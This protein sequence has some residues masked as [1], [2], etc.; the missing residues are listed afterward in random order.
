MIAA[1]GLEIPSDWQEAINALPEPFLDRFSKTRLPG[2]SPVAW[3][4]V[5]LDPHLRFA[6]G[7]VVLTNQRLIGF[8]PVNGQAGQAGDISTW[9]L[10]NALSL[11]SNE[12]AGLG[13]LELV[14][15]TVRLA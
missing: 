7:L 10:G 9:T 11:R 5:N 13:S 2:E 12:H 14:N 4:R 3:M 1:K 6:D 15:G 8:S